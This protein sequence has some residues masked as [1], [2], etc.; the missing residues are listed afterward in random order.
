MQYRTIQDLSGLIRKNLWKI[1]HD[2]DLVVGVPR[3]GMLPANMI[4]LYLNVRLTDIDSFVEG[5]VYSSGARGKG[6]NSVIRKVLV[7]DDS[8][9]SGA[10]LLE[11]KGKLRKVEDQYSFIYLTPIATSFG[12]KQVDIYF[13]IIDD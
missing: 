3:S 13:E 4:A 12:S 2:I 6:L 1:P 10:S 8:I 5:H 9:Y 11:A 7:V